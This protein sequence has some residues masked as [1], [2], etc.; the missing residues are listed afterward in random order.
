M[1]NTKTPRFLQQY[2]RWFWL[3]AL[4]VVIVIGF[5]GRPLAP[6]DPLAVETSRRFQ[7][8]GSPFW[9]GTDNLGRDI[10]SRVMSGAGLALLSGFTILTSAILVGTAV[11]LV[12]GFFGGLVDEIL[13]RLSDI[14]IAFPGLL[15]AL[16]IAAALGPNLTNAMIAIAAV[17]WPP[18]ARLVRGQVLSL[19]QREFVEA[20]R[21]LGSSNTWII[22]RHILP[23]VMV[24]LVVQ[25]TSDIGPA[26][27][28]SSSLSFIGMGAQPP[29]PE[30]G[31]MVSQGRKY[32]LDYWWISTFPGAAIF[33][34]VWVFNGVGEALRGA[35]AGEAGG[36]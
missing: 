5:F 3:I 10:A 27:V 12:S 15:L 18:Y 11:G 19:R 23:N 25:T 26:L 22:L 30:W 14:F 7:P 9:M 31:S 17:W 6:Y 16:A 13:M 36:S 32:L 34:T 28:T 29:T 2:N 33:L 1:K 24:P 20:A 8:P 4:A 21:S 35:V